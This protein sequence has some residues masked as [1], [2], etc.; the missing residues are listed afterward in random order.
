MEGLNAALVQF[1]SWQGAPRPCRDAD[2]DKWIP[3]AP[4]NNWTHVGNH[5]RLIQ[6][7]DRDAFLDRQRIQIVGQVF[8]IAKSPND[9]HGVIERPSRDTEARRS[10]WRRR[11]DPVCGQSVINA[12]GSV[13][14]SWDNWHGAI[15]KGGD[16]MVLSELK[17][18]QIKRSFKLA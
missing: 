6:F 3:H 5:M 11:Y 9:L 13:T 16:L 7:G 14:L 2:H 15:I 18:W 17:R 4:H 1:S 8:A 12:D 10:V